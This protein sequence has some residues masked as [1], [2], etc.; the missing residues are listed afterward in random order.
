MPGVG[1]VVVVD[2]LDRPPEQ[3]A[4]RVDVIAPDF[5]PG[6]NLSPRGRGGAGQAQAEPDLDRVGGARRRQ[7]KDERGGAT[8]DASDQRD[9]IA[10]SHDLLPARIRFV[11]HPNTTMPLPT[12]RL[13]RA[14]ADLHEGCIPTPGTYGAGFAGGRRRRRSAVM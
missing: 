13:E 10:P 14:L 4:L 3:A 9:E 11:T 6:L 12:I 5:E 2:E 1:L 8:C 7:R